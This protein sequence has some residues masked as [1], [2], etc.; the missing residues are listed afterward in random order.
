[1]ITLSQYIT[2]HNDNLKLSKEDKL[3]L[4][5]LDNEYGKLCEEFWLEWDRTDCKNLDEEFEKIYI[6]S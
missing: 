3:R 2:N 1:M 4:L 6:R 5:H